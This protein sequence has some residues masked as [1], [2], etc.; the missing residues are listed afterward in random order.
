MTYYFPP[1]FSAEEEPFKKGI[2]RWSQIRAT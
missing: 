1:Y 2:T